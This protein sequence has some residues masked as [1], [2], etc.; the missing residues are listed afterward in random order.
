[1]L[2]E[3]ERKMVDEFSNQIDL[4]NSNAI[5]QYGVGTQKKMADFSGDAL[6]N[7]KTKDMGEIGEMLSGVVAELKNF[8][9]EQ[10]G[11]LTEAITKMFRGDKNAE[12]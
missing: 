11:I 3:E 10:K 2:T 5:L 7:V 9:E 8:D 6:D 12:E 4:H 1:M